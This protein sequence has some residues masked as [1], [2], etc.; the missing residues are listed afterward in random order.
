MDNITFSD[1]PLDLYEP[2]VYAQIK[3]ANRNEL[4]A[5]PS[6]ILILTQAIVDPESD[7]YAAA[8]RR[9]SR[10]VEAKA[11]YG[12]GSMAALMFSSALYASPFADISVVAL[13][14]ADGSEK[15]TGSLEQTAAATAAGVMPLYIGGMEKIVPASRIA[16]PVSAGMTASALQAAVIAAVNERA[17]L[18]VTAEAAEGE[19]NAVVFTAKNAGE[20]GNDI[21][22]RIGYHTDERLPAGMA[23][24][25]TAMNGGT[26]NPDVTDALALIGDTQYM[27][28]IMPWTDSANMTALETELT[29]RWGPMQRKEA[30]AYTVLSAGY[31]DAITWSADHNSLNIATLPVKG[32]PTPSWVM[33]SLLGAVCERERAIDPALQLRT[34]ELPGVMIP[35]DVDQFTHP[36]R[37]LLLQNGLSTYTVT[38]D[39]KMLLSR[40]VSNYQTD[41]FDFEDETFLDITK[42]WAL[43]YTRYAIVLDMN[44]YAGRKKLAT[45]EDIPNTVTVGNLRARV[46]GTLYKLEEAGIVRDVKQHEDQVKVLESTQIEGRVNAVI[47]AKII[48]NLYTFAA[49]I[50]AM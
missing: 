28:I 33:A 38:R 4:P 19:S 32:S 23:V 15:A 9:H 22:I 50:E 16:I 21:D 6:N 1:I 30:T 14:D 7:D 10:T 3:V 48:P 13:P 12:A 26:L 20:C 11:L 39:G 49:S 2:G 46:L 45:R 44:R 5:D 17:D 40:V 35:A 36:E 37:N 43:A 47:P 25:I 27:A 8:V 31:G 41:S 42:G 34:V 18:P 29:S 24:S